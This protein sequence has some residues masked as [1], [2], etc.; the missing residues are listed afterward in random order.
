MMLI[1]RAEE[2]R[3]AEDL[4][5]TCENIKEWNL[6]NVLIDVADD[7]KNAQTTPKPPSH[8]LEPLELP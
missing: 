3:R 2:L 1:T 5:A 6:S 7:I 4:V 8:F